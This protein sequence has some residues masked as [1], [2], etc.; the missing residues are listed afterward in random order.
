VN[1]ISS[2]GIL[3]LVNE[4]MN[5]HHTV[6]ISTRDNESVWSATVFYVSDSSLNL[7]F[8]SAEKSKHIQQINFNKNVSATIYKD[9][10]DWEKIKGIQLTGEVTKIDGVK[11][12]EVINNYLSKYDFLQRV[13]NSPLNENEKKIGSQFRTIPFFIL[14]PNFIRLIDNSIVFG[15]KEEI[16]LE[17]GSWVKI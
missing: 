3:S 17:S 15:H 11:R 12:D 1:D 16:Q 10:K 6:T 4:A 5:Q 2:E 7:F 9:Q 13:M 14:K 8:L